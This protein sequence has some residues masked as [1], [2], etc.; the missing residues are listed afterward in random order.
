[1]E[2]EG[3]IFL[4]EALEKYVLP[5]TNILEVGA[6]SCNFLEKV[7]EKFGVNGYG[8]DPFIYSRS[9]ERLKC[10]A[11]SGEEITKLGG[12][13]HLIYLIRSFHHISNVKKFLSEAIF[14]L[15]PDG[16]LI[17]VDWKEGTITGVPEYYYDVREVSDLMKEAGFKIVEAEEGKW[18]FLVVGSPATF[19]QSFS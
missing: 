19:P 8:V 16:E 13:F 4:I 10:L 14:V 7:V 11:M 3:N 6:G 18:N 17:I 9:G 1:M 2:D 12:R 5:D 15:V